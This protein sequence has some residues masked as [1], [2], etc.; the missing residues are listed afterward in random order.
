MSL[1]EENEKLVPFIY[2]K[3]FSNHD[4]IKSDLLQV[5]RIALWI[6]SINFNPQ[7]GEFS[8][9]ASC[10]IKNEMLHCL[11][12][13]SKYNKN[14]CSMEEKINGVVIEDFIPDIKN[15]ENDEIMQAIIAYDKSIKKLKPKHKEIIEKWKS[16]K[17]FYDIE[18]ETGVSHQFICKEVNYFKE[19]LKRNYGNLKND[20]DCGL[21]NQR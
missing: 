5:G 19:I 3:Y 20:K 8:T 12:E 15:D 11:K 9:Y 7:I 2:K 6:G 16:G 10:C 18:K 14:N 17:N 21:E 1:F 13:N 4:D